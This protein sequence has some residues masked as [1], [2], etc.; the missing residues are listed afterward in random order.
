MKWWSNEIKKTFSL[1][2]FSVSRLRQLPEN[3]ARERYKQ[4]EK[5]HYE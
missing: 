1:N 2:G 4:A 3:Q 5:K